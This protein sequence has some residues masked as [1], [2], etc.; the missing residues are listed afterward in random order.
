MDWPDPEAV[1]AAVADFDI[2][3][4]PLIEN[5]TLFGLGSNDAGGCLVAL[6]ETFYA[7][8]NLPNRNH[9]L[10][11]AH[12]FLDIALGFPQIF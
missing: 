4:Y 1:S 3:L 10:I 2:G 12:Y 5:E 11:F 8:I 9:N 7:L 6:L